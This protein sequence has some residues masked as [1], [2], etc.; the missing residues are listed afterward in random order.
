MERGSA[1]GPTV[2]DLGNSMRTDRSSIVKG[3]TQTIWARASESPLLGRKATSGDGAYASRTSVAGALAELA[4]L[5]SAPV[6]RRM[7][8][9]LVPM[10][11]TSNARCY[12]W[13]GVTSGLRDLFTAFDTFQGAVAARQASTRVLNTIGNGVVNLIKDGAFVRPTGGHDA[14]PCGAASD[15]RGDAEAS[16]ALVLIPEPTLCLSLAR[17]PNPKRTLSTC[18]SGVESREQRPWCRSARRHRRRRFTLRP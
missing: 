17:L 8:H 4:V 2:A 11:L 15:R 1:E 6:D 18:S 5:A 10:T 14:T 16:D 3:R 7:H 12:A 13:Q 9:T